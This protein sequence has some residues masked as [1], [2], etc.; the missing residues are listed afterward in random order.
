MTFF[1]YDHWGEKILIALLLICIVLY[2]M[3]RFSL[4]C[5]DNFYVSVG[6]A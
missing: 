6:R 4:K 1:L 5:M 3:F 2:T